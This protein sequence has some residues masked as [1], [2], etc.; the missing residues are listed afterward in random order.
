MPY[1]EYWRAPGIFLVHRGIT[2]YHTH[3]HDDAADIINDYWYT[4]DQRAM[5]DSGRH[6]DLRDFPFESLNPLD[7]SPHRG[8]RVARRLAS[9]QR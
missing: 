5:E 6:F 9:G 4:L 7:L 2:V 3:R 1:Q 8:C